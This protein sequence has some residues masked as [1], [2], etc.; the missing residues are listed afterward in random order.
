MIEPLLVLKISKTY[1]Q[2][3]RIS[4]LCLSLK[5]LPTILLVG[6]TLDMKYFAGLKN[7]HLAQLQLLPLEA[8]LWISTHL[9]MSTYPLS[10][11]TSAAQNREG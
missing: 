3:I 7:Y 4:T 6:L 1:L 9:P 5:E 2:T 8:M 11:G 10:R